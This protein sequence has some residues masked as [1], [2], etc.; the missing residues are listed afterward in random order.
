MLDIVPITGIGEIAPGCDLAA[1]LADAL[2]EIGCAPQPNDVLVVTSK[3]VSK[4][5]GRIAAL[6]DVVADDAAIELAAHTRK[7]PRLVA[8]VQREATRI[9]RAAPHVL[10]ACHRTGHVMAN[11]GIDQSNLGDDAASDSVLLLPP[12]PDGSAR[13]LREGMARRLPH[14]PAVVLSDSF[15]RPW[16]MGVVNVAIGAAGL[17][18][19][20][21][22]RG[23]PDRNG[24]PMA[25]T[26]VAFADLIASAAGLVMG[27]GAEGIPAV[28][29]RGLAWDAPDRPAAALIRPIEEDLFQ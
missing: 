4:A 29:V 21:D 9:V 28:L 15:G 22:R 7:D 27:E 5:E 23:A 6:Q 3:I 17:P 24:R 26:Q 8:L 18:A 1:V 11:A 20:I 2:G 10:I 13:A 14:P 16:R 25:V 12:D 19:L